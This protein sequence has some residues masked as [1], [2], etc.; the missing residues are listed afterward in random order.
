MVLTEY[1]KMNG[2]TIVFPEGFGLTIE[3]T[4]NG[5]YQIDLFD[6]QKRSVS[7]HGTDLDNMAEK[8][9]ENLIKMRR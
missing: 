6:N 3:E 5:V 4:S 7:N 2:Q 8:A 9:I 1:K